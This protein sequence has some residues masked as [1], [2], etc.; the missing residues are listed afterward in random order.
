MPISSA[1]LVVLLA[2]DGLC[3]FEYGCA[4]EIFGLSRPEVGPTWYRFKVAAAEPGPL[5]GG[6]CI[7]VRADGDLTLLEDAFMVVVPGWRTPDAPVPPQLVAALR[8]AHSRGCRLVSLCGGAFVLAATGLL[9]GKRATTHWRQVEKLASRHP[10]IQVSS[11]VLYV[12][13]GLLLTSAGSAAALDLCLHIVRRDFGA[14]I[15]N[16]V[17]RRLV[18]PAHRDGGQL[19]FISQPV[20]RRPG[21][22]LMP[23]LD[24]IRSRLNEGWPIERFAS[25]AHLSIR[26]IHRH[27]RDTT[28]M[29]PGAWLLAERLSRARELLEETTLPIAEVARQVGFG[30]A[31]LLREHFR[32]TVGATPRAYRSRFGSER[33]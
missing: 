26:S 7:E 10:E 25:E 12:D 19:Q 1:P 6:G 14:R 31:G 16:Q 15:A 4:Y 24:R 17:G 13:E 22:R 23:L 29:A 3:T 32:K 20:P 8:A 9:A 21:T 2:Y 11:D 5:R 18:M 33:V 27:M 28:G 30:D